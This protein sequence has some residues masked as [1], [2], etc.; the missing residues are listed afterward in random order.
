[1]IGGREL[2][3]PECRSDL[4]WSWFCFSSLYD[5]EKFCHPIN[6]QS[7]AKLKPSRDLVTAFSRAPTVFLLLLPALIDYSDI[8]MC[9]RW[10]L[11]LQIVL[12]E[13]RSMMSP[14]ARNKDV[15]I[16]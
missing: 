12:L 15:F 6:N 13:T 5:S 9:F 14:H 2:F 11:R 3:V 8:L 16:E 7:D 4:G 10:L 1:M